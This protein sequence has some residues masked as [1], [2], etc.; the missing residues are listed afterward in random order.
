MTNDIG[1]PFQGRAWYWVEGSFGGGMSGTTLPISCYIQ[2][3]SIG[4]GDRH[5]PIR[6]IGSAQVVELMELAKE[7]TLSIEYYPQVG[8]T[9]MD[10]AIDRTS[11][12]TLQSMAFLI[13]ANKCM[14]DNDDTE[15]YVVGAKANTIRISGSKGNPWSV[16]IDFLCKSITTVT[17]YGDTTPDPLA[18]AILTFNLAGSIT[19]SSGHNAFIT[20]SVDITIGQNLTSYVDIGGSSP[21]YIVDGAMDISGTIDITLDGGGGV[22]MNEV[23]TNESFTLTLNMGAAGAPK[24]TMVGC[25]FDSSVLKLDVSGEAM[26]DS[27]PFTAAPISCVTDGVCSTSIVDTV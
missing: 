14:P 4:T 10:D 25:E 22:H 18:G 15:V 7:P 20:N 8:D 21:E 1:L 6:D 5:M 13:E 17:G 27:V 26:M 2:S 23:L 19:K 16:S 24:I 12:C 9:L 11:C 3:V